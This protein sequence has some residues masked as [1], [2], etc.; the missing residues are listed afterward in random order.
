[1][2]RRRGAQ[3]PHR[4]HRAPARHCRQ[5]QGRGRRGEKR[6]PHLAQ[7]ARGETARTCAGEGQRCLRGGR[8][9]RGA[10]SIPAAH[11]CDRRAAHGRHERGR[12]SVRRW[13]DV[14]AASGEIRA[15]DEEGRGPPHSLYRGGDIGGRT[16][17]RQD[18]DGDREGRRARHRQEH[19]RRCLAVQQLRGHRP[20][21]DGARADHFGY[22][23]KRGA[24]IIGLSGLITPSLEEMSHVAKE[25]KRQGFDI[26]LLIGGATTS[27]AH[28]AGKIEPH[29]HHTTVWV[30]DASRA[31]VVAQNLIS[32]DLRAD[33]VAKTREE[34][35]TL[36]TQHA[37]RRAH[38]QWL[39]LAQAR[40]NKVKIDWAGYVPPAPAFLGVKVFEDYPLEE[41]RPY[42]DWTPFFHTWEMHGSYPKIFSD[43][44]KGEEAKRLFA[45]AQLMLGQV[46]AKKWLRARA[47]IGFF[48][49]NQVND[50]DI[51]VYPDE[52]RKEPL[53]TLH[54]LRQQ[55]ETPPGRPN[56]CL[57]DFVA[58]KTS[59][60]EDKIGAFA[61]T[62]GLGIDA[63]VR[64]FEQ[65]HGDYR[66]IMLKAIADRFAA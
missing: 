2:C 37:G 10:P 48:P 7:L 55:D 49:A 64:R 47:V 54:H 42:I 4:R 45:D 12:R 63:H 59:E 36:R 15:G 19:R 52:A 11:S 25:M 33:F 40:A 50:D 39:T 21:R 66:A 16:R 18:R 53:M 31:V 1:M 44:A 23:E 28:T 34:Y 56:H 26:P 8:H 24:D 5:I 29:Y 3:S 57:S 41:I 46:I 30:K 14:F 61:V 60:L 13:Q 27:R 20:R 6:G 35:A 9:R 65:A 32:E 22:G 43:P 62:A 58:P 51:E 38:T 17:G